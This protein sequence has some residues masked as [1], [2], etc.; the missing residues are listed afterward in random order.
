M[1]KKWLDDRTAP[2]SDSVRTKRH[3]RALPLSCTLR[4]ARSAQ[5]NSPETQLNKIIICIGCICLRLATSDSKLKGVPP[6]E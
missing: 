3:P 2:E 5:E 6:I 1:K 4:D